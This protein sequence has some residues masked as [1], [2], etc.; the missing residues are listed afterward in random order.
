MRKSCGHK[1]PNILLNQE[2]EPDGES[3]ENFSGLNRLGGGHSVNAQRMNIAFHQ[4]ADGVIDEPVALDW[5]Q[6]FKLV[7]HDRDVEV[8]PA[9]FGARVADVFVTFVDYIE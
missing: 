9:I 5:R 8:T 1:G 4:V 6:V 7:R 3:V 2:Y